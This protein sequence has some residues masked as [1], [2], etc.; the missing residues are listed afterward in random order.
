MNVRQLV[1]LVVLEVHVNNQS[2]ERTPNPP[3]N[4]ATTAFQ[5]CSE[6]AARFLGRVE[7]LVGAIY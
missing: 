3:K 1:L 6:L 4:R 5:I 2:I 7:A